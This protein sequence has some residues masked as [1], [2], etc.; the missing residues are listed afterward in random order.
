MIS[1]KVLFV[2]FVCCE[3]V[4]LPA[5]FKKCNRE[6]PNGKMN[7]PNLEPLVIQ[8]VNV[9]TATGGVSLTQ[10]FKNLTV[11]GITGAKMGKLEFDFDNN[12]V[13]ILRRLKISRRGE[14]SG[15]ATLRDVKFHS[16]PKYKEVKKEDKTYVKVVSAKT[17][18][19]PGDYTKVVNKVCRKLANHFFEKVSIEEAFD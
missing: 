19:T 10:N 3:S 17:K 7:L 16:L 5:N 12:S 8:E 14:G 18:I 2:L 4:K 9:G 6:N 15:E 11:F 1:L 13:E